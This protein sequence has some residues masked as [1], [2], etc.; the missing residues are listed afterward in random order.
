VAFLTILVIAV[1]LS[2]DAMAVSLGVGTTEHVNDRRSKLRLAMHFGIFQCLMTLLGWLA[3]SAVAQF[4]SALDHWVAFALLAYVG[5][6]MIRSGSRPEVVSYKTN[7]SKGNMMVMLSVAT[8]LDA[9]AVGLSMAFLRVN[10]LYPALVIG[11]VT[12]GLSIAALF[13]GNKLGDKFGKKMEII[14]G[15]VLIGIGMEILVTHLFNL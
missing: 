6:T 4:I 10:I 14:G 13:L 1:G 11:V 5:V 9:M 3:G 15:I 12:F 2:M 8:S 7:P